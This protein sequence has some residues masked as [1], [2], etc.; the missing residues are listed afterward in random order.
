DHT[1]AFVKASEDTPQTIGRIFK[2]FKNYIPVMDQPPRLRPLIGYDMYQLDPD[3]GQTTEYTDYF[4]T[5]AERQYWMKMVD[6][7]YDIYDTLLHLRGEEEAAEIKNIYNRKTIF[8]A[9]TGHDLSV[10]RN[11][12]KRELQRHGYV[13]LPRHTLHGTL[14]DLEKAIRKDLDESNVSIHLIGAAYGEIPEGTDRS[15]VD[16]QNTLAAERSRQ[17]R[18]NNEDFSRLIWI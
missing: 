13:V 17:A 18:E 7:A 8:L 6:L 1:E 16:V 11:I 4:S 9:E 10:P 2:V 5:D 14:T 15:I 12:I 3:S